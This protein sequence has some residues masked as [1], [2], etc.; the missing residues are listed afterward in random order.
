MRS[1][2]DRVLV[3]V[4]T[5]LVI[6]LAF[7]LVIVAGL[8]VRGRGRGGGSHF[9]SLGS[10]VQS[11]SILVLGRTPEE[12]KLAPRGRTPVRLRGTKGSC[13]LGLGFAV[14]TLQL[15]DA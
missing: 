15:L 10:P 7:A 8:L 12:S 11:H 5:F 6:L 4:L 13:F 2:G 3:T 14:E 9:W 1:R